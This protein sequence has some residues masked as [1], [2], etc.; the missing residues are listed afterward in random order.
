MRTILA[1]L[2]VA[3]VARAH[4]ESGRTAPPP[5]SGPQV[6]PTGGPTT[7]EPRI[8]KGA[9]TWEDWWAYHRE[10]FLAARTKGPVSGGPARANDAIDRKRYREEILPAILERALE[11]KNHEVRA[12]AAVAMG[13]LGLEA[14]DRP[15]GR[16]Q[17]FPG[18]GWPDV[19]ESAI[20]GAGLLGLDYNRKLFTN[21][22]GDKEVATKERSL[23]LVGLL[24]DGS[25]ESA[26]TLLWHLEFFHSG[27]K[28]D[29]TTAPVRAEQERRRMAA[30]LLG[31]SALDGYDDELAAAALGARK[32]APGEQALAVTA[33]G[34]R[35]ARDYKET[36]FRIFYDRDAD[37][38]VRRSVP[39]ALGM[40]LRPDDG[41][42][43]KRLARFVRDRRDDPVA[44][45]FAVLALAQIGGPVASKLLVELHDAKV[46]VVDR[47]R[48]FLHLALGICGASSEE[49]RDALFA[50]YEREK[51]QA[52]WAPQALGLG[53]ARDAR[54]VALT[55]ERM[56]GAG[57]GGAKFLGTAALALG[58]H[59]DARGVAVVREA[60]RKYNLP[61]VR[62]GAAL[63]LVMLLRHEAAPELIEIL[64]E[65]GTTHGRAAAVGALALFPEPTQGVVD[66][67][68][69]TYRDDSVADA[70][71]AM[72][73]AALGV[74]GDAREVAF[75]ASLTRGYNYF[76]RCLALDEL[77]SLL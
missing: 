76:V 72:A 57:A 18:E 63:A 3:A 19:R 68:V 4:G 47:D 51:S 62:D 16:H 65:S 33:L 74:L 42:D 77:A 48:A 41:D 17:R 23:A 75:S 24:V 44:Q 25:R 58:F 46:F 70:V 15:L 8:V 60:F 71:R 67:L 14:F 32:W 22:A 49:A 54:A 2:L 55:I 20:Y 52:S 6:V 9:H 21:L 64:E 69:A 10:P 56:G 37:D 26:D 1:I 35:R 39:I 43:V 36:L 31:F 11:D 30:H 27:I 13:K 5:S 28:S 59:G 53:I 66:A 45:H 50:A 29:A 7:P 61:D 73:I 12:A 40:M 38:E 34:R